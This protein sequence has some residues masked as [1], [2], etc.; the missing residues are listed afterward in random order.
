M[1]HAGHSQ[2]VTAMT[3]G[4]GPEIP[5][6]RQQPYNS[7]LRD[8]VNSQGASP[9]HVAAYAGQSAVVQEL[10]A[11]GFNPS[12]KDAYGW[13]PLHSAVHTGME[14]LIKAL[15]DVSWRYL[16]HAVIITFPKLNLS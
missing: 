3:A 7:P 1:A 8:I 4:L 2:L 15:V 11:T 10:L 12:L 14:E 5:A 9:L 13:T 6:G 16:D